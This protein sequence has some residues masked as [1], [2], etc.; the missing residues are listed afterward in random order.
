M[1]MIATI[2]GLGRVPLAPGTAASLASLLVLAPLR[3]TPA[4]LW[5]LVAALM[6]AAV[7]SCGAYARR[8]GRRDPPS[9]VADEFAGMGLALAASPGTGLASAAAAFI[10]FRLFDILKPPPLGALERLPRGWGIVA[11]DLGAALL[12]SGVLW[13]AALL[14]PSFPLLAALVR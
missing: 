14:A 10:L 11:D 8:L 13:L 12:S 5:P 4:L 9:A 7:W 1:S 2:F 6:A 3:G